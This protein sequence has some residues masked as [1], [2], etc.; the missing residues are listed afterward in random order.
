MAS[1]IAWNITPVRTA[2]EAMPDLERFTDDDGR[3]LFDL[4]DAPRPGEEVEAPVRLLPWFDSTLLAYATGRRTR[5]LPDPH[6]DHVYVKAN[7]QLKPSF[8]VDGRVAGLWTVSA[9]KGA[10]AL[11][12]TPLE[13]V[14]ILAKA[15]LIAEAKRLLEFTHPDAALLRGG[16]P[17]LDA[18]RDASSAQVE[19]EDGGDE[20]GEGAVHDRECPG[21]S[22]R[23]GAF[24]LHDVGDRVDRR[25]HLE[26]AGPVLD[27]QQHARQ[28]QQREHDD[29]GDAVEQAPRRGPR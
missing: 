6:K 22:R 15:E 17:G 9:A 21:T 20:G 23:T 16:V 2:L 24:G 28:Q 12:L 27:R 14:P 18:H 26:P 4:P 13:R 5:I 11:I 7:G 29:L 1:W 19:A 3:T 25:R 10:A 8:L